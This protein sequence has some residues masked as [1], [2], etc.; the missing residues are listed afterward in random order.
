MAS[1][2]GSSVSFKASPHALLNSSF[3]NKNFAVKPSI[4]FWRTNVPK[5]PSLRVVCAAAKPETVEKV[6]KIVKSQLALKDDIAVSGETKFTELGA[7]SLDTVEIVMQ[8]EEEFEISVNEDSAQ[9]IATIHDAAELIDELNKA[10]A[11]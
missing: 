3:T 9:T 11:A 10:K 7:D 1:F 6:I 5:M 4:A 8:L 2:V